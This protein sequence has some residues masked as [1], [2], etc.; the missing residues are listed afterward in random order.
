MPDGSAGNNSDLTCLRLH[1]HLGDARRA[2]KI[3]VDLE[4]RM[5]VKKIGITA[6]RPLRAIGI[7]PRR[8]L[9]E[10]LQQYES[11]VAIVQPSPHAQAK[12]RCP[13]RAFIAARDQCLPRCL[14]PVPA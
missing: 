8:R 14:P 7:F 6:A 12:R 11:M 4:R 3:A 5:R 10:I 1:Q 9:D 13:A 2:A